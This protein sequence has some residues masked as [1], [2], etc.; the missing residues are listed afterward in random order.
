MFGSRPRRPH[1]GVIVEKK[2]AK[3]PHGRV[4]GGKFPLATEV[5]HMLDVGGDDRI[6]LLW[7]K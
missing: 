1:L 7:R 5:R 3:V 4:C 6:L 2:L